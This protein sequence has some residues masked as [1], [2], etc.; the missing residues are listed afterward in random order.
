MNNF[1]TIKQNRISDQVAEQIRTLISEGELKP[2]DKLPSERELSKKIGVG[3]LSLREGLRILESMGILKTSYGSDSGTYVSQIGQNTLTE[4][5]LELLSFTDS[6]IEQ[7]AEARLEISMINL[8]YF[9]ERAD[10][11]DIVKL[12]ECLKQTKKTIES[13]ISAKESNM[14]FHEL[15]AQG[16]KNPIFIALHG[17]L[18]VL[19]RQFL[20]KFEHPA[21]QSI[22]ILESNENIMKYLKKR[23]LEN[24]RI[25]LRNHHAY[26]QKRMNSLLETMK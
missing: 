11:E 24:A 4:K 23:D 13:G 18:L 26:L 20:S 1:K 10:D 17:A 15:I 7:L 6:S 21:R 9:I 25:A 12:E 22:D 8:K 14:R 5:F 16:S 2:G 19:L 3:R